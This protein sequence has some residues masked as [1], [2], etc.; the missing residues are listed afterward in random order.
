MVFGATKSNIFKIIFLLKIRLEFVDFQELHFRFIPSDTL[1]LE[2]NVDWLDFLDEVR[3][4]VREGDWHCALVAWTSLTARLGWA[5]VPQLEVLDRLEANSDPSP[6]VFW[7]NCWSFSV[8]PCNFSE[9]PWW[10]EDGRELKPREWPPSEADL[11]SA[12]LGAAGAMA[13]LE[14]MSAISCH[15]HKEKN[16]LLF[17]QSFHIKKYKRNPKEY[18]RPGHTVAKPTFWSKKIIS[19]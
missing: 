2:I 3:E 6:E 12:A 8:N 9:R 19:Y 10:M 11:P 13:A 1:P 15:C 17:L 16:F 14:V 18:V 5:P 4:Q 7:P